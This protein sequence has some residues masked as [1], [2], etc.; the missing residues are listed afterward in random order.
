VRDAHDK[1]QYYEGT[2]E[3]ITRV[4]HAS[5]ALALFAQRIHVK[6]EIDQAILA[7]RSPEEIVLSVVTHIRRLVP[8]KRATV[9]LF[10]HERKTAN[11]FASVASEEFSETFQEG[12]E[13]PLDAVVL[14]GRLAEPLVQYIPDISKM[15]QVPAALNELH[16]MGLNSC[17]SISLSESGQ[18]IGTLNM[19][20]DLVEAFD[21]EQRKTAATLGDQLSIALRQAR[22]RKQL[23]ED[24]G[25]MQTLIKH[26]PEGVL[27]LDS[28][29]N[30]VLQNA[31][32]TEY[33][34]ALSPAGLGTV[35]DKLGCLALSDAVKETDYEIASTGDPV[36]L[37]E[38]TSRPVWSDADAEPAGFALVLREVTDER[39]A[40]SRLRQQERQA[41]VGS[42][43]SGVAH[44]FNN[45]ISAI[46]G[47]AW[48][49]LR[50][51]EEQSPLRKPADDIRETCDRAAGLVRQLLNFSRHSEIEARRV[52]LNGVVTEMSLMLGR[53]VGSPI[54]LTTELAIDLEPVWMDPAQLEQ[55]IVNLAIN[56]RDAMRAG[57]KLSIVT[58]NLV[59]DQADPNWPGT[60]EPGVYSL[61]RVSDTGTGMDP[62]TLS[63][64]F[65]T[66]FTTKRS[67][68][69]TGLG[70]STVKAIVT[71][72][73]GRLRVSSEPGQGTTF[74]IVLPR[75]QGGF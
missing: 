21:D 71:E 74:E 11:V 59:L 34:A 67:E 38:L 26:L 68:G 75:F 35:S 50:K 6:Q 73:N 52:N 12:Q 8:C 58:E 40:E 61:M 5:Q 63:K 62:A 46:S 66:F 55:I 16:Q 57:G 41:V 18:L 15:E 22:M 7:A 2:V 44:D 3:D 29:L 60:L 54:E 48:L 64:I 9:I 69:G 28:E 51:L 27:L 1:V 72:T 42:L 30:V 24:R 4:K 32:A 45:L 31:V 70:L 10:D 37:F 65:E 47:S 19:A 14:P 20:S 36:R 53:L 39:Q 49:L 17:L 43:A 13:L 23:A 56:A 25:R 33:L